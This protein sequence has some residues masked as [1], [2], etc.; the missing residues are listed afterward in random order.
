MQSHFELGCGLPI[1][2]YPPFLPY[3]RSLPWPC[4]CDSPLLGDHC[5]HF[6]PPFSA[7]LVGG[8]LGISRNLTVLRVTRILARQVLKRMGAALDCFLFPPADKSTR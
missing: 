4:V 5:P 3:P 2:A 7:H 8:S 6:F 1:V